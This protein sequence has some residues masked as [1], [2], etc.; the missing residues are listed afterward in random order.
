[1]TSG[2]AVSLEVLNETVSAEQA[3][4][5]LPAQS[6]ISLKIFAEISSPNESD[7]VQYY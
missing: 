3:P 5:L 4:F 1:M 2:C 6:E 7:P